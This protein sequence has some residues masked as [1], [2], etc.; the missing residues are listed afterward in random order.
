MDIVREAQLASN[1]PVTGT[2]VIRPYG[3]DLCE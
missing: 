1:G 3:Y 2:M